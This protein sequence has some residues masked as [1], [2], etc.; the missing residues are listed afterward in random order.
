MTIAETNNLIESSLSDKQKQ[1]IRR[2]SL[3]ALGLAQ[4]SGLGHIKRS[5]DM[6]TCVHS[7]KSE[8]ECKQLHKR[9]KY[10]LAGGGAGLGVSALKDVMINLN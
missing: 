1:L 6:H 5:F 2:I 4:G 10:L 7:G 3:Y 9:Y 8:E